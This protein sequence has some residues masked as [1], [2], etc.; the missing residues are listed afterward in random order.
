M[1]LENIAAL[2]GVSVGT[3]SKAFRGSSEISEKTRNKIFAI[4]KRHSCF[5]KYYKAPRFRP[6]IALLVPEPESEFYGNE[7]GVLERSLFLHGADTVIA[8]TRFSPEK[9]LRLFRIFAYEMKVDGFIIW[10]SGELIKNPYKI[11]LIA[12]SSTKRAPVNSEIINIDMD[13][14]AAK[15]AEVLK[16]YG[17]T[18]IGFISD[19]YTGFKAD[20]LKR[21]MRCEGLPIRNEYMIS[22]GER[23]AEAGVDGM[24]QIFKHESIP[25]VIVTAY[26]EI[27]F[28]AMQY[29]ERHG[30]KIPDD[31]SFVG[32]DDLSTTPYIGVP[33]TSMHTALDEA[34]DL[35]AELILKKIEDKHYK[36]RAEI[37]IPVSLDI[38]D[39][40]K[41]I[42]KIKEKI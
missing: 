12:L 16:S 4:A 39:S 31:I 30:F 19:K 32:M 37:T 38:R 10:S 7:I 24:K 6:I 1:T 26:D 29:A 22:S 20:A 9:E 8:F 15:L 35:I 2:A 40:L 34:S 28:G 17:H 23:F 13:S 27:A 18:K 21:A 25:S 41:D 11:P 5:D 36:E 33:L 42:S 14:A 3:V